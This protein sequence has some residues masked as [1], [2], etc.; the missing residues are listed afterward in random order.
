M[1]PKVADEPRQANFFKVCSKCPKSCCQ[2]ARPPLTARRK[3]KIH[4]FWKANGFKVKKPFE[5]EKYVF[6]RESKDGYCI[7]LDKATNKCVVHSVKP[8]TC[9]AGP[10]TFDIDKR[11]GKIEWHLKTEKICPLA[12]V[13]Y[14]DRDALEKHLKSAKREILRL[15]RD[16]DPDSLE[17]ILT[18]EEPDTFK[19]D[20]DKLGSKL[21]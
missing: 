5:H 9:V 20:E 7:F 16:L 14:R 3:R 11:S 1:S 13:L 21:I 12:G 15:V 17:A 2:G 10:I 4:E 6:L 19:V 18:I 8:E